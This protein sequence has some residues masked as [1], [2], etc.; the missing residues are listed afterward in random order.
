MNDV[1]KPAGQPNTTTRASLLKLN[2]PLRRTNHG[3]NNISYIAPI[4]F[5]NLLNTT[6]G[7]LNTYK[8]RVKEH[9]FHRIRNE[10]NNIYS[11]F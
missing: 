4:I 7:N 9:F 8:H 11:Y 6:I 3:Q 5:N 2:Q 1:F 10:A